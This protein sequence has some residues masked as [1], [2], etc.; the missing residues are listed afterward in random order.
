MPSAVAARRL[1]VFSAARADPAGFLAFD[2]AR[3]RFH[4]GASLTDL[5][6]PVHLDDEARALVHGAA[7]EAALLLSTHHRRFV[8]AEDVGRLILREDYAGL[9]RAAGTLGPSGGGPDLRA[10]AQLGAAAHPALTGGV[11]CAW[12]GPGGRGRSLTALFIETLRQALAEMAASKGR[13]ETPVIAVAAL[14]AEMASAAGGLRESLAG[15]PLD[16]YLRAAALTALWVA[17]R[18][19]LARAWREAGRAPDEPLLS[20]LEALLS[21]AAALGGRTPILSGGS[22]LY[23]CELSAGVPRAEEQVARLAA[24]GDPDDAI[25]QVAAAFAADDDL[26]RRAEQAAAA[27]RLREALLAALSAGEG[28]SPQAREL[29]ALYSA[30]GGLAGALADDAARKELSRLAADAAHALPAGEGRE[31]LERVARSARGWKAKEPGAAVGLRR[32]A[33]RSEYAVAAAALLC[34]LALEKMIAPARRAVARRTGAEA[35]GGAEAEWEAGRLYRVS[36]RGGPI[37]K[38]AAERPLGHHFADVKDF[39]RRTGILGQAA[40]ADFLRTEFYLPI[41][42]AAKRHFAGMQHLADRGG[43][44]VNNLVGD[45]ISFSG[46]IVA[47]VRLAA[48]VRRLLA[49]YG[50]RLQREVTGEMVARQI[51]EIEERFR[52]ELEGADREL[53]EAQA[54]AARAAGTGDEPAAR[55][56]AARAEAERRRIEAE[57]Q[58]ALSRAR[59]EGL[60][61]GVFV[62]HGAAP[63]VVTI[64]D[65]VFGHS[66]VAIADKINESARG[67]ARTAGARARADALLEAE[68]AATGRPALE[69]AWSVFVGRPLALPVPPGAA[70]AALRA[71]R[72]G[73]L[74]AALRAVALPVRE[75]LERAA[76]EG[77]DAPA[78]IYNSGAAL[79]GAALEAFLDEVGEARVVRRLELGPAAIPER[80]R[81]RWWF[82][83]EP[84]TLVACFQPDGRPAELF[85][86]VGRA[87][88]RGIG[89]V[90]VWE[91][92]A[93]TGAPAALAGALAPAWF[94]GRAA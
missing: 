42:V 38:E 41:L 8:P 2:P 25:A 88:F 49:E 58:G 39:T 70:A 46:G 35:E 71:A 31:L 54:A 50:A 63:L 80:L 12:M 48:E 45:A 16:R 19:G 17:A 30:P 89:D 18:T 92:C 10:A 94:R 4:L 47:L 51:A 20:R 36:A 32:E 53:A 61:A 67:T 74:A 57:R 33:A 87:A 84:Q 55:H 85:R 43:V 82:G 75:A 52:A 13:E 22:T 90:P 28:T 78:D 29:A 65:E 91:I 66:R 73:D 93:D 68:R 77:D 81:E 60:E 62:S 34:D 83:S 59:G 79:S 1:E 21:P 72:A 69:H 5:R 37:L 23:G 56:R 27:G 86:Q 7:R 6:V 44:S 3:L 64:D 26:S 9:P 24:G 14:T 15:P 40:M 11:V 76:R